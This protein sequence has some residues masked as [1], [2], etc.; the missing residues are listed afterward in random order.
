MSESL[1][2]KKG[3]SI[4]VCCYNSA[5]VIEDTLRSLCN[6]QTDNR[7]DIELLI[8]DNCSTDGTSDISKRFLSLNKCSF[9]FKIFTENKAGLSFARKRGIDEAGFEYLILCDDDN[10]LSP[11]YA[12]KSFELMGKSNFIGALG[13]FGNAVSKIKFPEWFEEFKKSYSTG[14]QADITGDIT[15]KEGYVW[16]AG[17]VLRKTAIDELFRK[18]FESLLSDRKKEILSSGGDVEICYALR[19]IGYEI[20]YEPQL[21]FDHYIR[22]ERLD[23]K[24]LRLLY[25]G[26]GKQKPLLEP[27]LDVYRNNTA[28]RH[29]WKKEATVLTNRIRGYGL[30]KLRR[31]AGSSEGDFEVLRMEKT[32]GRLKQIVKMKKE[33]EENFERIRNAEWIRS[34]KSDLGPA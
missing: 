10:R 23:W 8:I 9:T 34:S 5:D 31:F 26:F 17:M 3:F 16:G 1:T 6:L 18:G 24:H 21:K 33:Y 22:P 25:R 15:S 29:S 27:Y 19:L 2:L 7:F 30:R 4:I 20:H 12:I 28:S 14:A 11:D 32:I 13:G